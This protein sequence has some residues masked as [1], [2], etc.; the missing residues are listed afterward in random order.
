MRHMRIWCNQ[1]FLGVA[2]QRLRAGVGNHELMI[3]T[4]VDEPNPELESADIAFGK[5]AVQSV[6]ASNALRWAHIGAA[7]YTPW[8]RAD[9]FERLRSR[10]A[11]LT[12][13]SMV[14]SEPCAEHVLSLMLAWARQLPPAFAAQVGPRSWKQREI[15]RETRLLVGQRALIFGYGSIGAR[16]AELLAPFRM[17]LLGV[18]DQVKGDEVIPTVAIT[19]PN[20]QQHLALAD[21]VIDLLP[22]NDSTR[23]VF[24]AQRFSA[25]RRGAIFYNIGRGNTVDQ[26]ALLASLQAGHLGA[27]LLDVSDPEPLP[28]DH[29]LWSLPNCVITPHTAG[30]HSTEPERLVDHFLENLR[31]FEKAAPLLDRVV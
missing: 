6:I 25:M 18:R 2:E 9:L 31:R 22:L 8:D 14:Y 23:N 10:G 1:P 15:R 11:A 29:P 27:A 21:H 26:D 28:P 16:L 7:G 3:R 4:G 5:P 19:D 17:E 12:R 30:G 24:D 13:S 20:L